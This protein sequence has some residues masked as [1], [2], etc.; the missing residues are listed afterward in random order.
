MSVALDEMISEWQSEVAI[1]QF[2]T[3]ATQVHTQPHPTTHVL[4]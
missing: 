3:M 1:I 2:I 4:K